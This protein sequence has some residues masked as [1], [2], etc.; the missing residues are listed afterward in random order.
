MEKRLER[1]CQAQILQKYIILLEYE[2]LLRKKISPLETSQVDY[3]GWDLRD[4]LQ[5]GTSEYFS[6]DNILK[7]PYKFD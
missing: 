3:K 6:G 5:L 1:V 4:G 7:I 2:Y